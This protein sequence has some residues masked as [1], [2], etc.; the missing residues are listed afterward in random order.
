[1]YISLIVNGQR[2]SSGYLDKLGALTAHTCDED[3]FYI[4]SRPD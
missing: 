4:Y 2:R 1:M 3:R